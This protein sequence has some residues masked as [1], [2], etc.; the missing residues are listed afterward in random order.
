V[1]TTITEERRICDFCHHGE[2]HSWNACL[3]CGKD[4]CYDCSEKEAKHYNHGVYVQGSGDGQ[5]CNACDVELT[6]AGNDPLHT[7]YRVVKALRDEL[8]IWS[9]AFELR[10]KRAEDAIKQLQAKGAK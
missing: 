1:K 7:A 2:A 8:E 5:Y 3:K 4:I 6:A 10:K 9:S